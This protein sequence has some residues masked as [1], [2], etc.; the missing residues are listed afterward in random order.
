V[1]AQPELLADHLARAGSLARAIE[2]RIMA[3]EQ[4][5]GRAAWP[6]AISNVDAGLGLCLLARIG[7]ETVRSAHE[8]DLQLLLA[9]ALITTKSLAAV[10]VG[11]AL[12]RAR[13]LC[14]QLDDPARLREVLRTQWIYLVA[15]G[16]VGPALENAERLLQQVPP[17]GDASQA[18][19][20]EY[21]MG[22]SFLSLGRPTLARMHLGR[23]AA[24]DRERGSRPV[25]WPLGL[26]GETLHG[27]LAIT[28]L[29]LGYPDQ[30]SASCQ[31]AVATAG[32]RFRP[33]TI[34]LGIGSRLWTYARDFTRARA[35]S[36][37]QSRIAAEHGLVP[38]QR[39]QSLIWGRI[40]VASGDPHGCDLIAGALRADRA[41][42]VS[43]SRPSFVAFYAEACAEAGRFAAGLD[44]LSGILAAIESSGERKAEAELLRV[45]GLIERKLGHRD[46]AE[47]SLRRAV[48]VARGQQA[49]FFELR[50]AHELALLLREH[51]RREEAHAVLAPVYA[52][53]TEGFAFPDL[54]E[55]KAL[56]GQLTVETV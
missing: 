54:R 46:E 8:I 16:E 9:R 11:A 30:A 44:A 20:A 24:R 27:Y 31:H 7:G 19:A 33:R 26:S 39:N 56:I 37:A 6:E 48:A 28:L 50:A 32:D 51:G 53:F 49:K 41:N 15:S 4:A 29:I 52:W 10:E 2:F 17:H 55:A 45:R 3:A 40:L 13:A 1:K 12:A 14:E 47:T 35:W 18:L 43:W 38:D 25:E 5:L 36:E 22:T 23:V 21:C 42:G 34:A